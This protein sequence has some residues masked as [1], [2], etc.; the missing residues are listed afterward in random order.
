MRVKAG[1]RNCHKIV[2]PFVHRYADS[3]KGTA[4]VVDTL[5]YQGRQE[6]APQLPAK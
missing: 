3:A 5:H 4:T 2:S 6:M 1:A